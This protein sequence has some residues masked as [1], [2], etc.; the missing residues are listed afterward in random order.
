[1]KIPFLSFWVDPLRSFRPCSSSLFMQ[2]CLRMPELCGLS[3]F[4]GR[5]GI[6]FSLSW[7]VPPSRRLIPS[8]PKL[9]ILETSGYLRA[10]P[11]KWIRSFFPED[12]AFRWRFCSPGRG[13]L[14][15]FFFFFPLDF[16]AGRPGVPFPL[17]ML[18]AFLCVSGVPFLLG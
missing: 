9:A 4:Y 18:S 13:I 1:M 10:H 6:Q 16:S 3:S 8:S 7:E 17:P 2:L 14:S 5:K 15:R 11:S 12:A